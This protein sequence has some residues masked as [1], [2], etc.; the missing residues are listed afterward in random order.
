VKFSQKYWEAP[1]FIGALWSFFE[2]HHK[3]DYLFSIIVEHE[4]KKAKKG[5]AIFD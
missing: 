1:G 2:K 3:L 4:V 5:T